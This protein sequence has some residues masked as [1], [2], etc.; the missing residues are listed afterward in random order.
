MSTTAIRRRCLSE[1]GPLAV[2]RVPCS[3]LSRWGLTALVC[4]IGLG[5][6]A[7]VFLRVPGAAGESTDADHAGWAELVSLGAQ[8]ERAGTDGKTAKGTLQFSKAL[9]RA[10]PKILE[11]ALRGVV[12]PS[13]ELEI[14]SPAPSA[15]RDS[16]RFYRAVLSNAW[17]ASHRLAG[18]QGIGSES[19]SIGFEKIEWTYTEFSSA[20][21]AVADHALVWD[22]LRNQGATTTKLRGFT[23]KSV[24][25]RD[26]RLGVQWTPEPG[27]RYTLLRSSRPEGPYE[28]VMD[29]GAFAT[30]ES[31][32]AELPT[33]TPFDFFL[34]R[35]EE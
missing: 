25:Q 1:P 24:R 22:F 27:R 4:L 16:V 13:V 23:V 32:W 31:R 8:L 15:G 2:A 21:A 35:G 12:V 6:H 11:A 9:D 5:L 29:L 30:D 18:G 7:G 26:G 14:V 33:G 10:T 28:P 19:F 3:G 20:G 17:V 34:V